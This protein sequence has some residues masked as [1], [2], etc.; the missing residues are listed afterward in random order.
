MLKEHHK[1]SCRPGGNLTKLHNPESRKEEFVLVE[2]HSGKEFPAVMTHPPEEPGWLPLGE[3]Y[4]FSTGAFDRACGFFKVNSGFSSLFIDEAGRFELENRG[5]HPAI[6]YLKCHYQG[7]LYI[8]VRD[9][10]INPFLEKYNFNRDWNVTI[11]T[12]G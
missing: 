3:R 4:W 8:A 5:F 11:L 12:A 7:R 1:R 9:V 10:F 2:L 6:E